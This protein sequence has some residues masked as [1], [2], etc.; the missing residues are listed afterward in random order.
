MKNRKSEIGVIAAVVC[1][2][3]CIVL[4]VIF[5]VSRGNSLSDIRSLIKLII[6][7]V[8]FICGIVVAIRVLI[9]ESK[10]K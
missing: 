6:A 4:F 1:M 10:N 7:G 3:I 2:L 8:V 9:R 5:D